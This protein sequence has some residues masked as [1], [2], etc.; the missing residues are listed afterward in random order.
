MKKE[1]IILLATLVCFFVV[2]IFSSPKL[3]NQYQITNS[4]D[5]NLNLIFSEVYAKT[6]NLYYEVD[7]F[8][9]NGKRLLR[10]QWEFI[11]DEK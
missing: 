9:L 1:T 5:E 10:T 11:E 8:G 3:I 4:L 7:T 2:Y 6:G